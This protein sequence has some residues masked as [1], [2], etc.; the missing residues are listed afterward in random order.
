[1][2]FIRQ[3]ATHKVVIGPV[4]AVTDGFTPITT[5]SVST[6]DEAEVI[7]HDNATVVSISG[8]TFAAITTA[9][10][11]Y[12]LTLQSGISGTVGHMTVVINDDSLCLPVKA[13]FTIIEE[14]AYD[15]V[16]AAAAPGYVVDQPVNTTKVAGTVQTAGDIP[17]LVT[18]VDTVVDGIQT[19]LSNGTDGLG[20]IKSD[21]AAILL[22]TV[23]IGTAGAG[24]TE[25]GGTG[26]HLTAINLPN[27]T[28]DITGTITTATNLTNLPTIP[29]DWLTAAGTA[30]D[31]TTEIQAGLATSAAQTTAQNDL[32]LITGS[33][34][35]TLA[36]AQ[37]LYAPAK[38]GDAMNATQINGSATAAANLALSAAGIVPG[39]T[40]GT[41]TTTASNTDLTGYLDDEL[42]GRDIIFTGGTANGQQST[43]TDYASASG[44]ITYETL[45]TAPAASDTF[46]I[47]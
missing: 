42:I 24:L 33:D 26:D 16:Y 41:P 11:Y 4:V 1:M 3:G 10:G 34:G 20:A 13:D 7:L 9:D 47:V 15:A 29:S 32:D 25:A 28:M 21:T 12:H 36:T 43:I 18:T 30:A 40:S 22:D 6:A 17:A 39:T 2:F 37:G 14:A 27:Q 35:A 5:L 31:F 46:V 38:A 8:Y 45:T 19:D 23:E 44:V